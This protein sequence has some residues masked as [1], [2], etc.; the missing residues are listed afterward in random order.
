MARSVV[1]SAK[2][3]SRGELLDRLLQLEHS[4]RDVVHRTFASEV[5]PTRELE[6]LIPSTVRN[7]LTQRLERASA[8]DMDPRREARLIDFATFGDLTGIILARWKLFEPIFKDKTL[9]HAKLHELRTLRNAL[10]HGHQ[11][12]LDE[13]AKTLFLCEDLERRIPRVRQGIPVQTGFKDVTGNQ[14][15]GL[16]KGEHRSDDLSAIRERLRSEVVSTLWS[17]VVAQTTI[18]PTQARV[19]RLPAR[20]VVETPSRRGELILGQV[21]ALYR[22]DVTEV[23]VTDI[24]SLELL[25]NHLGLEPRP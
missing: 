8:D 9:T 5:A 25:M 2:V 18:K 13:K 20:F 11:P 6:S 22:D 14:T 17:A 1:E 3:V 15:S 12:T 10:A 16:R 23:R 19:K 24:T 4:L 7:A 21:S